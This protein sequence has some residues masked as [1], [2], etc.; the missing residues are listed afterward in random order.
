MVFILSTRYSS[1]AI[2][3]ESQQD[4]E[5][6]DGQIWTPCQPEIPRRARGPI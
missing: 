4:E 1:L 3:R 2:W 6:T 5:E